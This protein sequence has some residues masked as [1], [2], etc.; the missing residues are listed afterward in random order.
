MNIRTAPI[1]IAVENLLWDSTTFEYQHDDSKLLESIKSGYRQNMDGVILVA[2]IT[3]ETYLVVT[4]RRK[5]RLAVQ[6]GV[7]KL[8]CIVMPYNVQEITRQ[9]LVE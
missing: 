3:S 5:A 6:A 8:P 1:E 7:K 9:R 2:P 4:G